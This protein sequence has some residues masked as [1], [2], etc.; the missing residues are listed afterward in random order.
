[1]DPEVGA[2]V[3]GPHRV[4]HQMGQD[5]AEGDHDTGGDPGR[6]DL[7]DRPPEPTGQL[8]DPTGPDASGTGMAGTDT[9]GRPGPICLV[10][11]D[12]GRRA[13]ADRAGCGWVHGGRLRAW[14]V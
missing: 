2:G 3:V 9:P 8:T 6:E 10:V 11:T 14:S 7:D 4:H 12:G 5:E 13:V 1:M